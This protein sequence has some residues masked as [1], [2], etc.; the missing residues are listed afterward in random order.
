LLWQ[1]GKAR[2]LGEAWTWAAALNERGQ[3]VG[4]IESGGRWR[5]F[6]WENGKMRLLGTS[7][8]KESAAV[9]LNEHGQ[10][11]GCTWDL[12]HYGSTW[13][14]CSELTP[15]VW[16]DGT[17][18]ELSTSPCGGSSA[19]AINERGQVVGTLCLQ[20]FLWQRGRM[21][22]DLGSL[23]GDESSAAAINDHGQ[24]VGT[25]KTRSGV[26]HAF[27]W[28]NGKMT[29]LGALPGK[30]YSGAVGINNHGQIIGYVANMPSGTS[31][32]REQHAVLWSLKR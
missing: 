2:T 29:D 20:A 31:R 25:S 27:L 26:E 32:Q 3:V 8:G 6:L 11:V 5:S 10:V 12:F 15:V 16:Q 30:K 7:P 9:A 17:A 1:G 21:W 22:R 28:Q 13:E 14:T 18:R 4:K 19:V 24:V 23:G